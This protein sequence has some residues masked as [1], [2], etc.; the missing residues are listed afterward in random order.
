MVGGAERQAEKLAVALASLG[1]NV[2]LLTPQLT[3]QSPLFESVEG[4]Q[5]HRFK[6]INLSDHLPNVRGFGPF[7][8]WFLRRQT[9][10]A[11]ASL[12]SYS[13]FTSAMAHSQKGIGL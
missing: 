4:I 11:V 12:S 1:L 6:M 13:L 3:A 7:N 10:Q 2:R 8:L 5:I 9:M